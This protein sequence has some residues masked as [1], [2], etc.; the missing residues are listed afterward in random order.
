[1]RCSLIAAEIEKTF[2]RILE[3]IE[4][5]DDIMEKLQSSTAQN[6]KEKYE[7]DLKR[8]IKKLQRYRD[9]IKTWSASSE[10]K[11]KAPLIEHRKLIETVRLALCFWPFPPFSHALRNRKWKSSRPLKR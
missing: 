11:D 2:K 7:A 3:G 5:F 4:E 1:M 6:L 9:Q 10:V 8:E